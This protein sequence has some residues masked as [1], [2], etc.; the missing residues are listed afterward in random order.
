[1]ITF[2][3]LLQQT[4]YRD[5]VSNRLAYVSNAQY[6]F[7]K[8]LPKLYQ[9]RPLSKYAVDAIC[10]GQIIASSIGEFND[11][12]E[13]AFHR[14]GSEKEIVTEAEKEWGELEALYADANISDIG[15]EHDYYVGLVKEHYKIDSRL[16]FRMLEYLGTYVSC[17]SSAPDSVLM[18]S[19]YAR[20][21]TG[22][23]VEYDFNNP[24]TNCLLTKSIFPVCY[25]D[26]PVDLSDL[27]DEEQKK[28]YDYSLEAAVLCVALNK[29]KSW[30]YEKEWR[31]VWVWDSLKKSAR[32]IPIKTMALPTKIS[33]GYHFL[34][35]LFYY[36]RQTEYAEAEN[37]FEQLLR[38][39]EYMDMN[40]IPMY[41]MMPS[42]GQYLLKPCEV[43]VDCIKKFLKQNFEYNVP[44]K[45]DYYHTIHDELKEVLEDCEK[46]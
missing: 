44:V 12:Y 45:I 3:E 1:M 16:K 33:F 7:P 19:H 41:I 39:I 29:S 28:T 15:V 30:A 40:N 31:L 23:C 26:L 46:E 32:R 10:S 6:S 36:D 2:F 5:F 9:Y 38:I 42:V 27:L 37:N 24:S 8:V 43:K 25:T 17:F 14:Y 35:P 11:L 34:R 20:S 22:I 4:D 13:G 18:W 21:N